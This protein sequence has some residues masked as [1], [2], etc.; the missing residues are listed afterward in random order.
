MSV[1]F[2]FEDRD[3]GAASEAM[4]RVVSAAYA[5]K[6]ESVQIPSDVVK[7]SCGDLSAQTADEILAIRR[8][9]RSISSKTLAFSFS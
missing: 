9:E 3:F 5:K 1:T 7:D 8:H 4:R 2:S 6:G